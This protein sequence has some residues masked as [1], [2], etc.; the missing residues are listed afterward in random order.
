[1]TVDLSV[2][3]KEMNQNMNIRALFVAKLE[4]FLF[5]CADEL[6]VIHK[7][8]YSEEISDPQELNSATAGDLTS[9]DTSI[10]SG[11]PPADMSHLVAESANQD[12]FLIDS[13]SSPSP[14]M[15]VL[16]LPEESLPAQAESLVE[17]HATPSPVDLIPT[18]HA[19]GN[20]SADAALQDAPDGEHEESRVE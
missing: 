9:T 7:L 15:G 8:S 20:E 2:F 1:M 17:D 11:L 13:S 18:S 19:D 12:S 14:P 3:I 6:E 10:D 4:C 16:S 5:C